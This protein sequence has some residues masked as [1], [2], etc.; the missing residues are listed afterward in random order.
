MNIKRLEGFLQKIG[1]KARNSSPT[2]SSQHC[3]GS[4]IN[5][6]RK[7]KTSLMDWKERKKIVITCTW[8]IAYEE[9]HNVSTIEK[10]KIP[11]TNKWL[12]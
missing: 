3:A 6:A 11:E 1:K 4:Q 9:N 7:R 5:K 2:T 10:K 8:H 12:Y